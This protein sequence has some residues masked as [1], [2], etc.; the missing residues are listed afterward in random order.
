[1]ETWASMIL[2]R[3][4]VKGVRPA[5]KRMALCWVWVTGLETG[6]TG[7]SICMGNNIIGSGRV[8]A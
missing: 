4:I 8:W 6:C 1:M 5:F 3:Y 7:T 2:R